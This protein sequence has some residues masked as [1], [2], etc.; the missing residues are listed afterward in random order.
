MRQFELTYKLIG[1]GWADARVFADGCG[2][3]MII[4]YLSD[5]PGDMMRAVIALFNQPDGGRVQF[6]WEDEPGEYRWI[7]DRIGD[8]VTLTI[9]KF[10]D[11]FSR[12]D[13]HKGELLIETECTLVR[14]AT[15]V[16]GQLRQIY[17]E[18]GLEGYREKWRTHSFPLDELNLLTKLIVDAKNLHRSSAKIDAITPVWRVLD[19]SSPTTN[20]LT[21]GTEF[22]TLQREI[23]GMQP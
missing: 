19:S 21:C 16:R 8:T 2:V 10:D 17:N 6:S 23:E 4:S 14:L 12:Q 15:Q 7:I 11:C 18:H 9:I 20:K 5:A 1:S 22:I 13:D 3:S